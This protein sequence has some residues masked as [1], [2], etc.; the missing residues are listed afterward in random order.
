MKFNLLVEEILNE[1]K[2]KQ[3]KK[4]KPTMKK[5]MKMVKKGV[6]YKG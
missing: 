4:T 2:M 6:K 5:K 3:M 1:S